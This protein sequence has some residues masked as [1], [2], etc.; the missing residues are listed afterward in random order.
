MRRNKRVQHT[1]QRKRLA[2]YFVV[3][4]TVVVIADF[5]VVHFFGALLRSSAYIFGSTFKENFL[6]LMFIEGAGFLGVGALFVGGYLENRMTGITGPKSAFD[7][8]MLSK[9]RAEHRRQQISVGVML[10]L[11]GGLLILGVI[12][13]LFV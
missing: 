4:L 12:I 3:F 13:G 5:A 6:A 10:M 11:L 1:I 8:E 2:L 9:D 7:V